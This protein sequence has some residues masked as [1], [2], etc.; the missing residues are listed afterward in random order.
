MKK[1]IVFLKKYFRLKM[2][3][4]ENTYLNNIK[5]KNSFKSIYIQLF[6]IKLSKILETN[7]FQR[8]LLRKLN[9]VRQKLMN[10]LKRMKKMKYK[11]INV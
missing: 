6:L 9:Y 10:N 11:K 1:Q 3:K 4:A 7:F 2:K 5:I 8:I